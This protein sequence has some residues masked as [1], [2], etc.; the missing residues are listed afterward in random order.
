VL[1]P[2]PIAPGRRLLLELDIP[3]GPSI[4][5]MGRVAWT[6]TVLEPSGEDSGSSDSAD[7]ARSTSSLSSTDSGFGIEFL[8]GSP[9]HLSRLEAFLESSEFPVPS[10]ESEPV[11]WQAP[12]QKGRNG[13]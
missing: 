2:E 3:D 8:G 9:E 4:Q 5:A 13:A 1:S 7:S 12:K 6:R 11:R 10:P